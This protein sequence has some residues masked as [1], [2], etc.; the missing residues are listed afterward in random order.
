MTWT[1]PHCGEAVDIAEGTAPKFCLACGEPVAAEPTEVAAAPTQAAAAPARAPFAPESPL[2]QRLDRLLRLLMIVFGGLWLAFF[3]VP[4]GEGGRGLVWS[5]DLLA[6]RHS[7]AH[8]VSWPLVMSL[9][10]LVLGIV[11]P[12]PA[13]LRHGVGLLGGLATAAVVAG[14]EVNQGPVAP[15]LAFVFMAGLPWAFMFVVLGAGLLLRVRAPASITARVVIA[16]GLLL[17]L[18][19]YLS[20]AE[21]E[22]TLVTA[23]LYHLKDSTAAQVVSRVLML[24][25]LFVMLVATVGFRMPS[26]ERDPARGWAKVVGLGLLVYLPI[27]LVLHGLTLS[28]AEEDLW[29]FLI[30]LRLAAFV[31]G[32]YALMVVAAAWFMGF[33]QRV[34]LPLLR[35]PA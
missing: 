33:T 8:L 10:F 1:C 13:W 20:P 31:A 32:L 34:L 24:L 22:D 17:G 23:L 5:W 6:S 9:V 28:V 2:D 18:V 19:A 30:F 27:M 14:T 35:R 11:S 16:L 7:M 21:G 25:P 3:F 12:L 29:F 15:D 26:G 4:W